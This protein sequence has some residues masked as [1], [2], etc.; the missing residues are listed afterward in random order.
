[1]NKLVKFLT[2]KRFSQLTT[3][4]LRWKDST[5]GTF[6]EGSIGASHFN[7]SAVDCEPTGRD[8]VIYKGIKQQQDGILRQ[9]LAIQGP[10]NAKRVKSELSDDLAYEVTVL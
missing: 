2:R 9:H 7:D 10:G 3:A 8:A 1:M 6:L 4:L 5:M